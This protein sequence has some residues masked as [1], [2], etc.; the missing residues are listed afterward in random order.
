MVDDFPAVDDLAHIGGVYIPLRALHHSV[1]ELRAY[2]D[3][4]FRTQFPTWS[5]PDWVTG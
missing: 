2:R 3:G 1:L 4:V 5:L